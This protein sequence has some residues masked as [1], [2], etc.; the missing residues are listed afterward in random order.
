[1]WS[2]AGS[3]GIRACLF[4]AA[5]ESDDFVPVSS[6]AKSLA[7]PGHFLAKVVQRL[8]RSGALETARGPH[9]G[10]RLSGA[11][12]GLTL[13]DVLEVLDTQALMEGCVLGIPSCSAARPCSLHP[14]WSS[15]V[16]DVDTLLRET[17]IADLATHH[18]IPGLS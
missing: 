6:I 17:T 12:A 9:G 2:K 1:M 5:R 13:R 4:L 3:Y 16:A 14:R 18:P 7:V 15:F 11:G 10:V 8:V